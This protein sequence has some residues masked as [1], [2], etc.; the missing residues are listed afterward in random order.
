LPV[1]GTI[2]RA[3]GGYMKIIIIL[4]Y[5]GV[6]VKIPVGIFLFHYRNVDESKQYVMNLSCMKMSLMPD[7]INPISDGLRNL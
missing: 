7:K 2:S 6:F 4:T 1:D 3:M 5:V